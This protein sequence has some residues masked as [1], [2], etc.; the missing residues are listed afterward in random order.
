MKQLSNLTALPAP[1]RFGLQG[2]GGAVRMSSV[3]Y[4]VTVD[5]RFDTPIGSCH[6]A[7]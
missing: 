4:G 7:P 1:K 3:R 5:G 2:S 6:Y